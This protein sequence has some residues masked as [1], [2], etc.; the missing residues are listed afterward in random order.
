MVEKY[1]NLL[2]FVLFFIVFLVLPSK[3]HAQCAGN[4]GQ[5][6]ICDIEN[7]VHQSISL[8]SLLGGS[9][10]P[11]GTWTDDDNSKGLNRTTG[12]LNGQMIR[13]GGVYHYTYTAPDV[14]GCTDKTAVVTITIGA[15]AGVPAP[16]ATE[17]SSKGTFNLF[18]AFNS[19][20]MGPHSNGNWTN[21]AG[22]PVGSVISIGNTFGTFQYTYTVPAVTACSPVNPSSTVI[23]TIFRAPDPGTP[24]DLL[25]CGTTD[26]GAYTNL[27]LHTLLAGEDSGG[28]WRGIGLTSL[29]DHE[30][31]L[32]DVFDTHGPGTYNYTYTVLSYPDNRICP[33]ETAVISITLEKRLDFTGAT[34]VVD[35]DICEDRIAT[36][37]YSAQIVQG[38]EVIPDG[39]YKITFNVSGPNGGTETITANFVNGVLNFPVSS[40]YFRQVGRFTLE[41]TKIVAITSKEACINVVNNL[42]DDLNILPLPNLDGALLQLDTVCQ[43]Q[44]TTAHISNAALLSN[45][46]Y[47]IVYNITGDNAATGQIATITAVGGAAS[48]EIPGNF[49]FNSGVSVITIT[50]I[51]NITN[52]VL[53]CSNSANL[54]GNLIINPLPNATTVDIQV[55]NVCFGDPVSAAVSG[56]GSLTDATLTYSLSDSNSSAVQTV[57]LTVTG[58]K[59]SFVVPAGL[60][61]NTGST[62]ITA[63][64]LKNNITS[65]DV[66]LTTVADSFLIS[67]IPA[68]PVVVSPQVFCEVDGATVANLA[69][70]GPRFKWFSSATAT[71]PLADTY[72]LKSENLY[73]REVS[74]ANCTS[75][76]SVVSVVVNTT[77]PPTLNPGGENF[78]GL[79]NP[80]IA[81]LSKATNVA[82][83][84]AW[85]DAEINGNLLPSTTLLKDKAT[86]YGFDLSNV[87]NCISENYLGVTVSLFDCDP[88]QYTFFI[89]DGFSPNGDNVN[90]T[91]RIPDIEFLY[92]DYTIEIFNRYGNIMFKGNKN[93]P[94]WDGKN[95]ESAGFGDGIA[96]NGVYFYI[97]NFNKDNR[98]PQQGRLYLNR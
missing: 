94:N 26:L 51:T 85:Y 62:T 64:N 32:Q 28:E 8:F 79:K 48:F 57:V 1:T 97:V 23:V 21:S 19:T 27:D 42:S 61:L 77:P 88:A 90:D 16:Y 87:T 68:A 80:T 84:V 18:T 50:S 54:K 37:T 39:A 69:P 35:S 5:I 12:I 4:D 93:K 55:E 74:A 52:P 81:D 30:V 36:A 43:K 59:A 46:N 15:Y 98:R 17:C 86:Y 82:A 7:P 40:A 2:R 47:R 49:N 31:N 63:T 38:P 41:V 70:N 14:A 20:V 71:T 65:C 3:I 33:D 34:I 44:K 56:L 22:Q 92:P 72:V 53:Q 9:P 24:R 6:T 66:N 58:G 76:S 11:G 73:V 95:S 91:F 60:L 29:T 25:L 13:R 78:C 96:P 45:G 75:A 89:P 67:P 83:T 10:T